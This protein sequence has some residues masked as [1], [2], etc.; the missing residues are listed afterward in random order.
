M[1]SWERWWWNMQR[2]FLSLPEAGITRSKP[3]AAASSHGMSTHS[4]ASPICGCRPNSLL[5]CC[6]VWRAGQGHQAKPSTP[7]ISLCLLIRCL[8]RGVISC[9]DG[10]ELRVFKAYSEENAC[11]AKCMVFLRSRISYKN[12]PCV[13]Q[14]DM[15]SIL[16]LYRRYYY[17]PTVVDV[18]GKTAT[19]LLRCP[20]SFFAAG[21][22][23]VRNT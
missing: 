1:T 17:W 13:Q 4:I 3:R 8:G 9:E 14:H 20:R 2:S 22:P 23:H 21:W 5:R 15:T 18:I 19:Y 6:H 7:Q 16:H 10:M 11:M 12:W